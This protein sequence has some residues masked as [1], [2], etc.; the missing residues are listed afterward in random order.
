M[1]RGLFKG[2]LFITTMAAKK[3]NKKK[4]GLIQYFEDSYSEI[5]KVQWPTKNT[6]VRLTFLVLGFVFAVA[7]LIGILD[8]V[9]GAGYRALLELAPRQSLPTVQT[10]PVESTPLN[11]EAQ[12]VGVGDGGV[13]T[14]DVGTLSPENP[15]VEVGDD[16]VATVEIG[17]GEAPAAEGTEATTDPAGEEPAPEESS[18]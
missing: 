14:V 13:P 4:N 6:A 2:I 9:F 17:G 7:I 15:N 8:F 16:G 10:A 5:R 11:G 12:T 1:A 3:K 18:T